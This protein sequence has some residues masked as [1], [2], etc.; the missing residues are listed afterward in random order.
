METQ[1]N[2][3][4]KKF[5]AG[6]IS[7]TIWE[8]AALKDGINSVYNTISIERVYKDKNNSWQTTNSFRTNDLPKAA[9][10]L[11]KAYESL[12]L[13]EKSSEQV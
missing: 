1:K 6:A 2:L 9:L 10:M 7:V 8:N 4:Q 11:G 3:P 13:Q 5:R 12:I